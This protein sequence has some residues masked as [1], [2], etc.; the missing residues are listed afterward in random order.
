MPGI[1]Q[2]HENIRREL[3]AGTLE[4]KDLKKSVC[5]LV[6]TVWNSNMYE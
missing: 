1:L 3:E 2:D 6:D 5:R 4:L